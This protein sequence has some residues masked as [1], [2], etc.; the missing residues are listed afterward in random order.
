[1]MTEVTTM[2]FL[3]PNHK[4]PK[5]GYDDGYFGPVAVAVALHE[6]AAH[7]AGQVTFLVAEH[8]TI[9]DK[10]FQTFTVSYGKIDGEPRFR[11]SDGGGES[12]LSGG[13]TDPVEI[14]R[15]VADLTSHMTRVEVMCREEERGSACIYRVA[16]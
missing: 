4:L 14:S 13:P 11:Y 5:T 6:L 2:D 9:G 16:S 3:F 15:A 7:K 12:S 10:V 8:H 1:M